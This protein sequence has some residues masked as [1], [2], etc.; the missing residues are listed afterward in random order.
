MNRDRS[1]Y[2][3][4]VEQPAGQVAEHCG[5]LAR[6]FRTGAS[7]R[8][9]VTAAERRSPCQA[10]ANTQ[11]PSPTT[12]KKSDHAGHERAVCMRSPGRRATIHHALRISS[13]S[14]SP[15]G[16]PGRA[17]HG[18][19]APQASGGVRPGPPI[20]E[21]CREAHTPYRQPP[22]T[23]GQDTL[24]SRPPDGPGCR[25]RRYQC[26][27]WRCGTPGPDRRPHAPGC[28]RCL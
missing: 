25:D 20:R 14:V 11:D 6:R 5:S 21:H 28:A 24:R 22:G 2:R 3:R 16:C 17:R 19:C 10:G 26:P 18:N 8:R 13:G 23:Q 9:P 27:P 4:I 1:L 15:A 7:L 12:S